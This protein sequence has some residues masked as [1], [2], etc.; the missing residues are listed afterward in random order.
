VLHPLARLLLCR[1]A[2]TAG[3]SVFEAG[4]EATLARAGMMIPAPSR[5]RPVTPGCSTTSASARSRTIRRRGRQVTKKPGAQRALLRRTN[6]HRS[7]PGPRHR[8]SFGYH[9]YRAVTA[10]VMTCRLSQPSSRP[11]PL[12]AT[13]QTAALRSRYTRPVLVS[14]PQR[15]GAKPRRHE[16]NDTVA[17]PGSGCNVFQG[18]R[19]PL[20]RGRG[21]S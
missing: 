5:T 11:P 12:M 18:G 10:A 14:L 6:E 13:P 21:E 2:G 4:A 20:N 8:R 19:R 15:R 17:V 3:R 16:M 7:W 1:P 9:R